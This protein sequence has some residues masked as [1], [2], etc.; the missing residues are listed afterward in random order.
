MAVQLQQSI[1]FAVFGFVLSIVL[2]NPA[3]GPGL[4]S[5]LRLAPYALLQWWIAP[6]TFKVTSL[7]RRPTTLERSL[8]HRNLA[9]RSLR[10]RRL[11]LRTRPTG[12]RKRC[13]SMQFHSLILY[14]CVGILTTADMSWRKAR[15]IL[16]FAQGWLVMLW[17]CPIREQLKTLFPIGH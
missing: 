2:T 12:H 9:C 11:T 5:Y 15:C 14:E 7:R 1:M 16:S 3:S 6:F 17:L 10:L 13:P 8:N 4:N